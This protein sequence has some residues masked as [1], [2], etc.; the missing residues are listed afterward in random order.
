MMGSK[1]LSAPAMSFLKENWIWILTPI[2]LILG[3]VVWIV[4]FS[5]SDPFA[6]HQYPMFD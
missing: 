2:V 1:T 5:E 3:A 6:P 4:F